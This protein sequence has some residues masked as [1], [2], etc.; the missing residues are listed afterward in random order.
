VTGI[1]GLV[2]TAGTAIFEPALSV[3]KRRIGDWFF[4]SHRDRARRRARGSR[5][6]PGS[7]YSGGMQRTGTFAWWPF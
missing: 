1:V 4:R 6:R 7:P 2:L 5:R 3:A